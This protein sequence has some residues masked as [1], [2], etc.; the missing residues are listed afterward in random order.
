MCKAINERSGYYFN[1][2]S[3]DSLTLNWGYLN[4]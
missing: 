3:L 4:D 1:Y 2:L